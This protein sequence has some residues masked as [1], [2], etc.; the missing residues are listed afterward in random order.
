M[1]KL[2]VKD[3]ENRKKEAVQNK[4]DENKKKKARTDSE[5]NL[6]VQTKSVVGSSKK[7]GTI[8]KDK[9]GDIPKDKAVAIPKVK[10]FTIPKKKAEAVT[11]SEEIAGKGKADPSPKVKAG[12]NFRDK[13]GGQLGGGL[14][15]GRIGLKKNPLGL[16]ENMDYISDSD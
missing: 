13:S 3:K 16:Q 8:P 6:Q 9:A 12:T 15:K 4:V 2:Y 7:A 1:R 11:S 5:D 10:A 14:L